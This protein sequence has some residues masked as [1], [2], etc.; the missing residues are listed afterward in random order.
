MTTDPHPNT[1]SL[2]SDVRGAESSER[3][4]V[5]LDARTFKRTTPRP[6]V[7]TIHLLSDHF[8]V[9]SNSSLTVT[10]NTDPS[11]GETNQHPLWREGPNTVVEG[12]RAYCNTDLAQVTVYSMDALSVQASLPKL[13]RTDN[14]AEITNQQEL[15]RALSALE[16]WLVSRVGIRTNMH[17]AKVTRLDI[18][19]TTELPRKV[20]EYEP[21]LRHVSFPRAT[22]KRYEGTGYNWGNASRELVFYDKGR[23]QGDGDSCDARLE[24]RLKRSQS[25]N[26]HAPRLSTTDSLLQH[27]DSL[28]EIYHDAASDLLDT[29][30]ADDHT[31]AQVTGSG[32]KALLR[33]LADTHGSANRAALAILLHK[34]D[35]DELEELYASMRELEDEGVL[36]RNTTRRFRKKVEKHMPYTDALSGREASV[37]ELMQELREAFC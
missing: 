6:G 8:T 35:E 33:S 27:M 12:G 19:C 15:G 11:T 2:P 22:R 23:E 37:S 3:L 1:D 29:E 9:A 31:A 7:D 24:Y 34:M 36:S 4:C 16:R 13:L 20:R 18:A 32:F 21:V 14:R 28:E 25:V 10:T 30:A 26:D 17:Q 5:S